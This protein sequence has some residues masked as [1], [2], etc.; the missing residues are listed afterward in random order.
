MFYVKKV[1]Y[2]NFQFF[3]QD[4]VPK[5]VDPQHCIIFDDFFCFTVPDPG[6]FNER[7]HDLEAEIK[8][9]GSATLK[10]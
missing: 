5:C 3:K 2:D 8:R 9:H 6:P 10:I 1:L 7:D 4:P